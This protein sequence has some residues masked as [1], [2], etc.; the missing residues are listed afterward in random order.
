[1]S[2]NE[3]EIKNIESE[4][5]NL[6]TFITQL[7]E[8]SSHLRS[9]QEKWKKEDEQRKKRKIELKHNTKTKAGRRLERQRAKEKTRVWS[10]E[11]KEV[12]K[13]IRNHWYQLCDEEF[14]IYSYLWDRNDDRKVP[15]DPSMKKGIRI[16]QLSGDKP[17]YRIYFKNR[18]T[19]CCY[20]FPSG[21]K[22][23]CGMVTY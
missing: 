13:K 7:D 12:R 21:H 22:C 8:T 2:D 17:L 19:Y 9:L 10:D 16:V 4:L 23:L 11:E 1:M 6:R 3:V 14:K 15:L 18:Y 20:L 5:E